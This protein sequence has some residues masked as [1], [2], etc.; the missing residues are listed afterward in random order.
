MQKPLTE[1][2]RKVVEKN[3][4]LI[5]EYFDDV[6]VAEDWAVDWYGT[7]AIGLCRAAI[8]ADLYGVRNPEHFKSFAFGIIDAEICSAIHKELSLR[9]CCVNLDDCTESIDGANRDVSTEALE[10]VLDRH[11][12]AD[13][14]QRTLSDMKDIDQRIIKSLITEWNSISET[15]DK[16]DVHISYVRKVYKTFLKR[17]KH[18]LSN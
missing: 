16:L 6:E 18:M 11:T 12:T 5:Q 2:Q 8:E 7:A 15:A 9:T 10:N 17:A 13:L 4:H 3:Y 14:M 1:E